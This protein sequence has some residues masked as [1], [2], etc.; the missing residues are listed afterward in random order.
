[1]T[2]PGRWGP[3]LNWRR[4]AVADTQADMQN[5]TNLQVAVTFAELSTR[6]CQQDNQHTTIATQP[7]PIPDFLNAVETKWMGVKKSP[8]HYFLGHYHEVCMIIDY[9]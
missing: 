3:P 2:D 8:G 9:I 1:M 6:L 7:I 4:V 5:C